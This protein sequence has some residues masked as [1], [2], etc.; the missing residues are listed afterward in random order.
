MRVL[1]ET[2]RN[3]LALG[4]YT[5]ADLLLISYG[6]GDGTV[7]YALTSAPK[8]F[9][10]G[11]KTYT[12]A[13][14]EV[15]RARW[16]LGLEVDSLEV[17]LG[18]PTLS[19]M[20]LSALTAAGVLDEA[21]VVYSLLFMQANGTA[22]DSVVLFSGKASRV[23]P[24]ATDCRM[25]VRS[26][27]AR[28][29]VNWPLRKVQASCPWRVYDSRCAVDPAGFTSNGTVLASPAPTTTT[30]RTNGTFTQGKP[31]WVTF[32][33]GSNERQSRLVR[34]NTDVGGTAR[35]ITLANPLPFAPSAGD[36]FVVVTG[37]DKTRTTCIDVFDNLVHYGGQPDCPRTQG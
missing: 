15:Q 1:S 13:P 18:N 5:T 19:G 9:V 35:D 11:G 30:F 12:P 3:H 31:G 26:A 16:T 37:C 27:V 29:D 14:F 7:E 36:T 32:T 23:R 8:G 17:V 2:L 21:E 28:M 4:R 20:K 34:A 10:Y 25:E 22:I 24:T 33:S 6:E